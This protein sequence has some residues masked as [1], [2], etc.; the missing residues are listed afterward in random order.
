MVL[1]GWIDPPIM[2]L[3][4]SAMLCSLF[5]AGHV[6]VKVLGFFYV[7]FPLGQRTLQYQSDVLE[8]VVL[9]NPSEETAASEVSHNQASQMDS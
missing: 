1:P 9:V 4:N 2:C 5:L 6:I 8:T 7:C 3:C